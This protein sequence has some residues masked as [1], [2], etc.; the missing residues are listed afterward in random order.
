MGRLT[1]EQI[2]SVA[3]EAGFAPDDAVTFTAIA[4]AESGGDA[5]ANAAG[6]EDSRGLWQINVSPGVRENRWGDLYDPLTNARAA[7]EVSGGGENLRPWSVTHAQHAGTSRDYR[8]Y[9]D[10][11]QAAAGALGTGGV[12]RTLSSAAP[13]AV[14]GSGSGPQLQPVQGVAD[15]DLQDTW[16][17]T[18]S[19]GRH[20]EGIDI[21]ADEG[22]PVR[23]VMSGE[24]VKGFHND[25]GGV[26]VRVEGDDGNF[27][28]YAH[29][30]EGS[31]DGLTVGQRVEVGQQIGEVG[32]T[33][34]AKGT[35]FHLHFG[36]KAG[37]QW[38]NPYDEL[39]GVP[40]DGG[41]GFASSST[42]AAYE[43]AAGTPVEEVTPVDTDGDGLTDE[44]EE[45][46]GTDPTLGDSDADDLSDLYE[47]TVSHS[48]P[49]LAD[50]DGDGIADSVEVAAGADAGRARLSD[51]ALAAGFGGGYTLDS[52]ADDLSDAYEVEIGTDPYSADSDL[53]GVSDGREVAL[54][55]DPSSI[56]SDHD[57]ITDAAED[58]TGTLEAPGH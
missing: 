54:G 15:S 48:D 41:L 23:A 33:G 12:F 58:L 45:L 44:F 35:P 52:D 46:L 17:A 29:L 49:L 42:A 50:T 18:R 55:A 24:V 10:E 19:G 4:L 27:Y 26:V 14:A 38:V 37:G 3:V 56:D 31:V 6:S 20:H 51:A 2:Y 43:I 25:L 11:A 30:K 36:M 34:N 40:L 57:G 39:Q 13:T 53:D 16:G 22:T 8:S 5:S 7:L 47:T 9:L 21:M 32:D 1:P 28:Y